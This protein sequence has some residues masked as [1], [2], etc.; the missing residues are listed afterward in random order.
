[1]YC[2]YTHNLIDKGCEQF[3]EHTIHKVLPK[4]DHNYTVTFSQ[5]LTHTQDGITEYTCTSCHGSYRDIEYAEG[6]SYEFV[7]HTDPTCTSDGGDTYECTGCGDSYIDV[8]YA[9][10]H[11]NTEIERTEPTCVTDGEI[12]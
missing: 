11:T 12:K 2:R 8:E 9:F 10:G 3:E 6:H 4:L 5:E 1:M 7:S